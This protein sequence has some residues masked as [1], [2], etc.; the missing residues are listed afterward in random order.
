MWAA[1]L[2]SSLSGNMLA[3]KWVIRTGEGTEHLLVAASDS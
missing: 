2:A 3:G 1:I